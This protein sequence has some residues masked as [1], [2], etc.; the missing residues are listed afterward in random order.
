[1]QVK[2]QRGNQTQIL[3]V[4]TAELKDLS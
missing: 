4:R 1:L 3:S 2:I